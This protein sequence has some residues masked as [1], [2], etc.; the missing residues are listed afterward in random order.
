MTNWWESQCQS[1]ER[2]LRPS[3]RRPRLGTTEGPVVFDAGLSTS[4]GAARFGSFYP[5]R[6]VMKNP[7]LTFIDRFM[8]CKASRQFTFQFLQP[9]GETLTEVI[10]RDL[11]TCRSS[12]NDDLPR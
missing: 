3:Q 8:E 4:V 5:H 6:E 2:C 9:D 11:Q 10:C 1:R 12:L 7:L